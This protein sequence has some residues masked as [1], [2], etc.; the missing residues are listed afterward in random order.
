MKKLYS[1]RLAIVCLLLLFSFHFSASNIRAQD[2]IVR[3][4]WPTEEW[5]TATPEEKNMESNKLEKMLEL[6]E[7]NQFYD[8]IIIVR[9]GYIILEKYYKSYGPDDIHHLWSTTRSLHV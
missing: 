2:S 4:Y 7:E 5:Q 8:S 1:L 9:H 6:I 3:D